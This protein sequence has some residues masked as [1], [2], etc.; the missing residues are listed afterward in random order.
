[1]IKYS[2][3]V[4]CIGNSEYLI[5]LVESLEKQNNT[6]YFELILVTNN[7]FQIN[8]KI[9]LKII[10][11]TE[12][13]PGKKRDIGVKESNSEIIIF[14]DDDAYFDSNYFDILNKTHDFK[15]CYGGKI[16]IPS[17]DSFFSKIAGLSYENL[18]I[19]FHL[20]K[21]IIL[22]K[23]KIFLTDYPSVNFIIN[24]EIFDEVG[25]FNNCYWP[26][27]DSFLCNKIIESNYQILYKDN[28]VVRHFRRTDF[29]KHIRQIFRYAKHRSLFFK[30]KLKNS[31][32]ISF[33][34]PS[35]FLISLI[36]VL[37]LKIK[38]FFLVIPIFYL[39][40]IFSGQNQIIK[41]L[42]SFLT[43]INLLVYGYSFIH[44]LIFTT[45]KSI[46]GR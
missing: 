37:F 22:P 2:I 34:I 14:I 35:F 5:K 9:N 28:L 38:L 32:K 42:S 44:G 12:I 21:K 20:L 33:L 41:I 23:K 24:K 46:L 39:G 13:F 3:I 19:N 7:Y 43:I 27:D 8:S 18:I 45:K 36:I 6:K 15:V 29:T 11:T 26:G 30:M 10:L 40:T 16:A 4:P 25:G 17:E 31:Y 1:M